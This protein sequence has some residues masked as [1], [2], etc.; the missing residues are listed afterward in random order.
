MNKTAITLQMLEILNSRSRIKKEELAAILETNVRNI[1]EYK[2]ELEMAG[3]QIDVINGPQGGYQ[4]SKKGILP[5]RQFNHDE[6][7][8]LKRAFSSL[9]TSQDASGSPALKRA[10]TTL[11]SQ[12]LQADQPD[13][14]AFSMTHLN[15]EPAFYQHCIETCLKAIALNHRLKLT[16]RKAN[17]EL[18]EYLIEP[19]ECITIEQIWYVFGFIKQGR[20]SSF[21]L[22]R[23]TAIEISGETFLKDET[24][25]RKEVNDFGYA[26]DKPFYFEAVITDLDFL[27][28]YVYGDNQQIDWLD[29][30]QFIISLTFN[31][32]VRCL[33]FVRK[34]SYHC[35]IIEPQWLIES[36]CEELKHLMK[37]Y[38]LIKT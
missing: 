11:S 28:E 36:Y 38:Q 37:Q 35:R 25:P 10:L 12:F 27:A 17:R 7:G 20:Y 34:A 21:K 13:I 1:K 16:Y 22:N 9:L 24:L 2:K 15:V 19:Y 4:L 31:S 14:Y 6:I 8:A 32:K 18:K 3:Y 33:D 29:D 26:I 30:H 5:L 23:I